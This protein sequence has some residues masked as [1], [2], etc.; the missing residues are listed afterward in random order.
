MII[1]YFSLISHIYFFGQIFSPFILFS[2]T[3]CISHATHTHTH[4]SFPPTP[5]H[6]P[7]CIVYNTELCVCVYEKELRRWKHDKLQLSFTTLFYAL[8]GHK[9]NFLSVQLLYIHFSYHLQF[10]LKRKMRKNSISALSS[11]RHFLLLC[12]YLTY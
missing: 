12:L 11:S 5:L 1:S 3:D 9:R 8:K 7:Y 6:D 10:L 2:K 4:T